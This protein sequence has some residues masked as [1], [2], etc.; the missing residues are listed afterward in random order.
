MK[1]HRVAFDE[2]YLWERRARSPFQDDGLG[3]ALPGLK[4][5]G[6][7]VFAFRAREIQ[8]VVVRCRFAVV[9]GSPPKQIPERTKQSLGKVLVVAVRLAVRSQELSLM[10][11]T[12]LLRNHRLR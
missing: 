6:Y 5:L 3:D 12:T 10:N 11:G 1:R 7:F 9:R 4:P 8:C 2:R